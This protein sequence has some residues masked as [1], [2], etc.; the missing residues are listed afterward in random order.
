M[1]RYWD[2]IQV[3]SN[4]L[5]LENNNNLWMEIFPNQNDNDYSETNTNF[6]SNIIKPNLYYV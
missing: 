6:V 1:L 3:I 2:E 4:K 5:A